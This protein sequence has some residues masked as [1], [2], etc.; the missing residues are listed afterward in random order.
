MID[1]LQEA[2]QP[3][4]DDL[5]PGEEW[6]LYRITHALIAIAEQLEKMNG[7]LDTNRSLLLGRVIDLE[8][9]R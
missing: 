7:S 9:D 5:D 2:K 1:H 3:T 6:F 4:V 8:E